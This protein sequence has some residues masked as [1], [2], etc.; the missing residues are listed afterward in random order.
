M[1]CKNNNR[2]NPCNANKRTISSEWQDKIKLFH[3]YCR[4]ICKCNGSEE[5]RPTRKV[6][7]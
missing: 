6:Y 4:N 7:C 2:T 1:L 5:K 3:S